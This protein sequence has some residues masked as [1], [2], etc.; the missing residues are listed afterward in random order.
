V[1]NWLQRVDAISNAKS[2]TLDG[3]V[4][5]A[6]AKQD[7]RIAMGT[8]DL[9]KTMRE[10]ATRWPGLGN[11]PHAFEAHVQRVAALDPDLDAHGSDLYLAFACSCGDVKAL[12]YFDREFVAR[13][14]GSICRINSAAD[15]VD[16]AQQVLRARLLGPPEPRILRYAGK[17][18]LLAWV[19]IAAVRTALDLARSTRRAADELVEEH[20]LADVGIGELETR[21]YRGA[22]EAAIR[23]VFAGL[24]ARDRN[25]LRMHYV[26]GL[27]LERL[28]A[29]YQVHRATAARWLA[30]LRGRIVE[31]V[32]GDM[33]AG[34]KLTPSEFQSVF[35]VARSELEA[36]FCGL[37]DGPGLS[38]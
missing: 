4:A 31:G 21:R 15:F 25:L 29:L 19:R 3:I 13:A 9:A 6:C 14:R 2:T 30:E 34:L 27:S 28:G 7:A 17:G 20:L 37:C 33:R 22:L 26:D 10:G 1:A 11:D 12:R 35:R 5:R 18:P 32:E 23:R 38:P 16:E 24:E 8:G 36:S